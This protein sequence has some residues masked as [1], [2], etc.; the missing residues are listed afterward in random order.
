MKER[1]KMMDAQ[2]KE[3]EEKTEKTRQME[4]ERRRDDRR[5]T[6]QEINNS[7]EKSNVHHFAFQGL[8]SLVA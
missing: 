2:N 8:S 4:T 6:I 3:T 7:P 1:S 5:E